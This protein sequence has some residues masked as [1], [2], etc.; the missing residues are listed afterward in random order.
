MLQRFADISDDALLWTR[1]A[2][3]GITSAGSPAHGVTTT[4]RRPAPSAST[5]CG[6]PCGCT[7]CS[8]RT[9]SRPP[10]SP[11]SPVAAATSNASTTRSPNAGRPNCGSP[12][13]E[14]RAWKRDASATRA[15]SDAIVTAVNACRRVVWWISRRECA[16]VP[17]DRVALA[18]ARE[19]ALVAMREDLAAA[20]GAQPRLPGRLSRGLGVIPPKRTVVRLVTHGRARSSTSGSACAS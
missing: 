6:P 11:P 1:G 14:P 20:V 10:S 2:D 18:D 13:A 9:R 7:A 15:S 3:G 12:T 4:R 8:A 19:L 17:S 16:G 5:T